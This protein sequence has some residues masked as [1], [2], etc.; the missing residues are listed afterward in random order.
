MINKSLFNYINYSKSTLTSFIFLLPLILIYEII[1]YFKFKDLNYHIRNSADIILR[2]FFTYFLNDFIDYYTFLLV[3]CLVIFYLFYYKELILYEIKPLFLIAMYV[4]GIILGVILSYILNSYY[5]MNYLHTFVY[6]DIFIL[7]Y[8]CLGAGIWEE[9][10]FRFITIT[11]LVYLISFFTNKNNLLIHVSILLS[12]I[13][14]SSF[15][16]IGYSADVFTLYTFLIRFVGGMIL[17]YIYFIRGL[18][19]SSMTH[20]CYDF[21]LISLPLI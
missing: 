6:D 7:F 5:S 1:H 14:F 9:I 2:D 15:H 21:F 11:G 4:E 3:V 8:M 20:F 19:I 10:L 17:G 16:Y 12:S 13:L 18:G